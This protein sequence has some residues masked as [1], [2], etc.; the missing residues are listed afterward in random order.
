[1]KPNKRTTRRT[2]PP[3]SRFT[4]IKHNVMLAQ[5]VLG[6]DYITPLKSHLFASCASV[7]G[8][9]S[10]SVRLPLTGPSR[11]LDAFAVALTATCCKKGWYTSTKELQLASSTFCVACRSMRTLRLA[12]DM[13]VPH[14]LWVDSTGHGAVDDTRQG[15][16][17]S[18]KKLHSSRVSRIKPHTVTWNLPLSMLSW[19]CGVFA[20]AEC[21]ILGSEFNGSVD[22]AVWPR[23][24]KMLIFGNSFNQPV[25]SASFPPSL[26]GM[27]FGSSFNQPIENVSWPAS[28]EIIMFGSNFVQPV[29]KVKWPAALQTLVTGVRRQTMAA[30]PRV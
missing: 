12:V 11:C 15:A 16:G 2:K 8:L 10:S 3:F 1:M 19:S 29:H 24:L 7:L 6:Y 4:C 27:G 5:D 17:S 18:G 22:E 20:N 28:L 23:G 13:T 26:T 9:S 14:R 25:D 21:L 30:L